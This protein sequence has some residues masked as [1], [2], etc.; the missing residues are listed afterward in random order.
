MNKKGYGDGVFNV[1]FS[2]PRETETGSMVKCTALAEVCVVVMAKV[3]RGAQ[4]P[5]G[6]CMPQP[7][8]R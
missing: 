4:V 2:F 5:V 8:R 6:E 3:K 7:R 1:S